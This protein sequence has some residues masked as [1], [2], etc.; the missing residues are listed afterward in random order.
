ML[1]MEQKN[2]RAMNFDDLIPDLI[3]KYK[4]AFQKIDSDE[5]YKWE[6]IKCYKDNWDIKAPDFSA[7]L[8]K[9]FAKT[10]NLLAAGQYFP[11]RMLKIAASAHPEDVRSL[12]K[13]LYDESLPLDERFDLFR[14]GFDDLVPQDDNHYREV[15]KSLFPNISIEEVR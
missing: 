4:A 1:E 6:A 8:E 11:L 3:E 14:A 5:R 9:A 13:M 15:A 2:E 10:F 7:M 12:F